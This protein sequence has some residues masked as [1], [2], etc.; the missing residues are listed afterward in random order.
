MYDGNWREAMVVFSK[1]VKALGPRTN[2][3]IEH[4]EQIGN[5]RIIDI[6]HMIVLASKYFYAL[7]M[8]IIKR[9]T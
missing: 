3:S 2:T 7:D 5:I 9:Y 1:T 8:L 4:V 6:N